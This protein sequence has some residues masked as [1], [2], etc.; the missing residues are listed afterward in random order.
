MD[1]DSSRTGM[2]LSTTELVERIDQLERL[3]QDSGLAELEVESEDLAIVLRTPAAL[4]PGPGSQVAVP[5]SP[6]P[7]AVGGAE[8]PR[9][10]DQA[11]VAADSGRQGGAAGGG[12]SAGAPQSGTGAAGA[13]GSAEVPAPRTHLVLAPLT[14]IYYGAPSPQAEPYVRAGDQ[15]AVGQVIGLIEAMKLFNEIKSDAGGRVLRLHAEN[16]KLIKAKQP[17]IEIEPL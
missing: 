6:G 5:A 14:G 17:L 2:P 10:A 7:D 3:L 8:V 9:T 12:V 11:A 1:A 15:V 4:V 13:A 16:G